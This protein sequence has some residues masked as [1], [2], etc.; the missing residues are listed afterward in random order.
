MKVDLVYHT[1]NPIDAIERAASNCYNSSPTKGRIMMDC[2]KSGH[3]SVLEFADF[4]F[5]IEGVS[6][7]L[8]YQLVRHRIASFAQRSQRYVE[9]DNFGFVI[10]PSVL[11]KSGAHELYNRIQDTIADAYLELIDIYGIP[12][13]DARYVLSNAT[14]TVIDVKMNLR[15]LINFCNERLCT[16]AQWEIRKMADLMAKEVIKVEPIL[17]E[18]LVPKCEKHKGFFFCPESKRNCCGRHPHISDIFKD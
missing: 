13:E 16:R 14:N 8:S 18:M 11:A 2:Y 4:H 9:E 15:S 12:K 3:H 17:A 6:R 7:A 10:P 5:H 1:E